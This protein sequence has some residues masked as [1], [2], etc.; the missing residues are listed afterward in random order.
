MNHCLQ[1]QLVKHYN[2]LLTHVNSLT[3]LNAL[4]EVHFVYT[5]NAV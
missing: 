5:T 1:Q 2:N 4:K 3:G